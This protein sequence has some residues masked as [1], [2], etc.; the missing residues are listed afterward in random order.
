MARIF[1]KVWLLDGKWHIEG[2]PHLLL[3]AKRI[4][5]RIWAAEHGVVRLQNTDEVCREIVWFLGRYPMDVSPGDRRILNRGSE[6]HIET[7]ATLDQLIDQNYTGREFK[8]GLPPRDYQKLAASILLERGFLLLADELGTGKAQPL[9][10]KVLTPSGWRKIGDLKKGD[11]IIDPDGGISEITGIHP[12]GAKEVFKVEM[13][14]GFSTECCDEHLWHV[15]DT[16]DKN[17][18]TSRILPLKEFREKLVKYMGRKKEARHMYFLPLTAAV[19]FKA[20]GKLPLDPYL[21][22][23]LLGDGTFKEH[24]VL[25]SKSD[26]DFIEG[27]RLRLPVG[28]ELVHDRGCDWRISRTAESGPNPLLETIRLLGLAGLESHEKFI[29]EVYFRASK[30][31]R[32]Q[33]LQGLMDTDGTCEKKHGVTSYSTSSERLKDGIRELVMGL[34]GVTTLTSRI[35]TY[36]YKGEKKKGRLSYN[37]FVRTPFNP[38]T[39][40]SKAI[41]WEPQ[42]LYRP[43][44]SA[45]SM[46][47]KETVCISTS[48][49]RQLYVTD[50]YIVTHNTVSAL[51]AL[52]DK[53]TLP[54]IV[55]TLT[56]TMP[57]QWQ[58]MTWRFMPLLTTHIITKGT[59]YELP[60]IKGKGPDVIIVNYHKLN[61]WAE[62]LAAYGRSVIFDECQELRRA[63]SN[64]YKAAEHISRQMRFRLGASGT[65]IYNMGGEIWNVV[66]VL[67]EDALGTW[68]EFLR[69][70]CYGERSYDGRAPAV[71][72]PKALGSYLRAEHIM[73]RRTRKEVGRELPPLTKIPQ[74][75]D[76]D[77][78][79]LN[80]VADSASQLAKIILS[81]E[82]TAGWDKMKATEE[83]NQVMRQATGVA[84]AP[85]IADFIRL[86]VDGDDEPVV[87]FAWHRAVY[88]ILLSRLTELA[89][90]MYTGT[91]SA[92]KKQEALDR[93]MKGETKVL[94]MSLRSGV[95]V[96]G[97]QSICR[98]VVFAELDWTPGV[99]DQC[100]G[101]V[102]RDGQ[103]EPVTAIFLVA[104]R[105]SDPVIAETLGLKTAQ[106]EGIRDPDK[107]V[108]E[109]KVS[110]DHIRKLAERYLQKGS[111]KQVIE[112]PK[113]EPEEEKE[114]VESA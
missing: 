84:K 46:G 28:V 2:E 76:S 43:I 114:E 91:E 4:F 34:G 38:F 86:I 11:E 90:A 53:R 51:A 77:E 74:Y 48:S 63:E 19:E 58:S 7:M 99:L 5:A 8:M 15:Q 67:Q 12:R 69:E 82:K 24:A 79:A 42:R 93:F 32:L 13:A 21:L 101:R 70:W 17:R 106:I 110:S 10:A 54:A 75:I 41:R 39:V 49:K 26:Q 30:G 62:T 60:R 40:K 27:V 66:N 87:V 81:N 16:N 107:P 64:K 94:L 47:L 89:P 103:K 73:L 85:Y 83:F 36:K 80:Q 23:A 45:T 22:G 95:G 18:G 29:P 20:Q 71:R 105:G 65:P 68:Q 100:I 1:G 72:D 97:L 98:T 102:F 31:E 108:V 14:D 96:D 37:V 56:G 6:R 113:E 92:T 109:N 33:L 61:G 104:E 25:I 59:P 9:D 112:F 111:K 57:M 88:D 78:S 44:H 52:T 3:R 55:V 50:G 35:P